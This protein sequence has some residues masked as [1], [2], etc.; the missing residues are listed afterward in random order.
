MKKLATILVFIVLLA[1]F[2]IPAVA[3][4]KITLPNY[5]PMEF[6]E[7][8]REAGGEIDLGDAAEAAAAGEATTAA[9]GSP[10]GTQRAFP[11]LKYPSGYALRMFT[12][13]A[14]GTYGEIWVANN[15]NY[16]N[17]DPR[18]PVIVTDDQI[19][20]LLDQFDNN[21]YVKETEFFGKPVP[22]TGE[23][24]LLPQFGYHDGSDRIIILVDNI[25]DES[26]YDYTYP[27]YIAGY[28]STAVMHYTDR[29]VITIDAYDWAN[30][31][32]P[33]D[34]PWRGPDASRWRPYL[35]E[36]TFA[37]EFQHLLHRDHDGDEDTW[38]NEG[39][40][41]FAEY[42]TGYS[43]LNTD[44]H[45]DYF[46]KHPYNSLV[47]WEDQ[48]GR[49]VLADYGA[50]YLFQLY[51][52][53]HYGGSDFIQALHNNPLNGIES[54]DDT[55]AQF[56]FKETFADVY[57]DWQTAVLINSSKPGNGLYQFAELT[58]RVDLEAGDCS[59]EK[60]LAWG[61]SFYVIDNTTKIKHITLNGI[62]FLG[63]PW[64]VTGDPLDGNAKVLSGGT[65]SLI[66]NMLVKPLDLTGVLK[67]T[68]TFDTFYEI[69]EQWD[70]GFV[71]VSLD[72]GATWNSLANEHTRSDAVEEAHPLVKENLPGFTGNSDGWVTE[73]FDLTPFAGKQILL[74]FRYV[75]DWA[76]EETGFF[77][78]NIAVP[79]IGFYAAGDSLEPFNSLDEIR[80]HYADYMVTF[81]GIKDSGKRNYKVMN[82][83]LV[84]FDQT[85]QEELK[86]FLADSSL[87]TVILCVSYAAHV[88][89]TNPV[90]FGFNVEY[91]KKPVPPP[92]K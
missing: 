80:E 71:Q 15:L 77:I 66:D 65:G 9:D 43:D 5:E 91:H 69:E 52:A 7:E 41:D 72:G 32:G 50:A 2:A 62:D 16:Q 35:Y 6:N 40:A 8:M 86:K 45:I 47:A 21:M 10:I 87:S 85:G 75:T 31:V 14:I 19:N 13:R 89:Q 11:V 38:I 23:N 54:V 57:R 46:L 22:R 30:R 84:N 12:L 48:G 34:S 20:Y 88:G 39:Q 60:A 29:N 44:G 18:N 49:E 61:P 74:A 92:K 68:L 37:H 24:A 56:G 53:E 81:V 27:N 64:V 63:T 67:A 4:P 28:F 78:R 90:P 1:A 79:E 3:A 42:L 33:N 55:L 51:L 17:N 58:K 36:G 83:K 25:R 26:Y 59:G 82:L 70:F 76:T 73:S